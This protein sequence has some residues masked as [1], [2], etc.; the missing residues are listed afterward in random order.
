M[1]GK[2]PKLFS[3]VPT[4]TNVLQHDIDVGDAAPIGQH[5]YRANPEKR[6]LMSKEVDYMLQHG[7]AE[8][9]ASLWSS[10]CLLVDNSDQTLGIVLIRARLIRSQNQI[11]IP[12]PG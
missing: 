11:A 2:H 9:S 1:I 5:P 6:R 3:D 4:C 10:L 12:F 7:I 8:P